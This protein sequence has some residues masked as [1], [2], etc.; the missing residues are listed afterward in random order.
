MPGIE[1]VRVYKKFKSYGFVTF[2]TFYS[3]EKGIYFLKIM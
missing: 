2:C 1:K 3:H